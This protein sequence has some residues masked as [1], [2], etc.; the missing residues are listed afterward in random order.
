MKAGT[1]VIEVEGYFADDGEFFVNK[2]DCED[3]EVDQLK[4]KLFDITFDLNFEK[5]EY[6]D[7]IKYFVP[8]NQKDIEMF[9]TVNNYYGYIVNGITLDSPLSIYKYDYKKEEYIDLIQQYKELTAEI[10]F[11]APNTIS[12]TI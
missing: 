11:I 6:I 1:N 8:K 4:R 12:E 10:N 7:D 3:Y 5:T 2:E 9:L